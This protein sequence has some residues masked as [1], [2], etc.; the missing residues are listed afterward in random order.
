MRCLYEKNRKY[1]LN[2]STNSQKD[3][4]KRLNIKKRKKLKEKI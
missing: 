3:F 1:P 4:L 2:K